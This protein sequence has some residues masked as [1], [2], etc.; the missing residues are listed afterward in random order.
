MGG[1]A[2]LH[3][4]L[5]QLRS[6]FPGA[7]FELL[8]IYPEADQRCNREDDLKVVPAAPLKLLAWYMPLTLLGALGSGVRRFLS[9][10]S[11]FFSS[12]DAADAVIDLSGIA[13]VDGRGLPLLWYNLSCALPGIIWGKPVFKLSQAL[14]PFRTTLNRLLAKPL[15]QHC[16]TVVA[17]GEQSRMF[18]IEL[19][20][21][22]P[23]AL[24]DVSFALTIPD[25]IQHQAKNV[26]RG[27][28]DSDRHWV[29]VSPSQV[30]ATL[31]SQRGI[32]FLEQMQQFVENLL[33]DD[34]RNVLIL[35]HSLGTGKS[36]NN[37]IDLCRELHHR[38]VKHQRAFLHIP[39]E[40]PV[41]LRAII[42]QSAFF[43]GCRFHAVV[44]ALITGAPC[45]ILGWS[46][47]YR[48]MAEAFDADIPSFDFS[49]FS[50]AA[51]TEAF[52]SAWQARDQTRAILQTN[53]ST[54]RDLSIKNFD[55]VETYMRQSHA[56]N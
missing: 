39:S 44:A 33:N 34:S 53:G 15:L 45:L 18:L 56:G 13:L 12:L 5:Q 19:G 16:S 41:L 1:S 10:R 40:D 51:L 22:A 29:I 46:H 20:M 54:V 36:K 55:L 28:D 37:D 31:C 8:S 25:G 38:L 7:R 6:R 14:G 9:R 47:K 17:R 50:A 27:L 21:H 52:H 35:P 49:A 26:L 11:A 2:M 23:Q 4:T 24:P 30:V 48:E 42:G 3:A 43:V 32:N